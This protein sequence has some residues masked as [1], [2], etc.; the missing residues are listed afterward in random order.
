MNFKSIAVEKRIE[1]VSKVVSG[2]KERQIHLLR[3]ELE[4]QKHDLKPT[5]HLPPGKSSPLRDR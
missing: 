5:R 4:P 1:A 2:E 3:E